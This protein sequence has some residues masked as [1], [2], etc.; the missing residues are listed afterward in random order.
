MFKTTTVSPAGSA[1]ELPTEA[2]TDIQTEINRLKLLGKTNG[3]LTFGT[4]M[5][6]TTFTG[7]R[8]WVDKLSAEEWIVFLHSIHKKYNFDPLIETSIDFI[9]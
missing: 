5:T 3:I 1:R 8:Q 9:T 6:D 4:P 7:I 2:M